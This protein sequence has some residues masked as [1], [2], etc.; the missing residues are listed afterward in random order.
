MLTR[1][2]PERSMTPLRSALDM[3]FEDP[4]MSRWS[5]GG[6]AQPSIDMRETDD[7]YVI[8]AEMPGVKAEDVEVTIDGRTLVMRGQFR[9]ERETDD[10]DGRYLMRERRTGTFTRA[11][12]LPGGIDA[13]RVSSKFENGELVIT[14][15]KAAEARARRIPIGNAGDSAR[16]VGPGPEQS[17]TQPTTQERSSR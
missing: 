10:Q 7:A 14:L 5:E 8:E 12:T 2:Y 13:D 16:R 4:W 17:S 15:P 1:R 6:L 3:L 9:E 11:I